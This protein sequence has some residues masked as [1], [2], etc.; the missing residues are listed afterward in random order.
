MW[1]WFQNQQAVEYTNMSLR[2]STA[3]PSMRVILDKDDMK[4]NS[5]NVSSNSAVSKNMR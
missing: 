1:L 3:Y 5:S 4:K 2:T